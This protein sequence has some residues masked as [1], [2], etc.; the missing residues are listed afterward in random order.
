MDSPTGWLYLALLHDSMQHFG[1]YLIVKK[2]VETNE[3]WNF[4][5]SSAAVQSK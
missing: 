4:M 2:L 5:H 3:Q 1:Y